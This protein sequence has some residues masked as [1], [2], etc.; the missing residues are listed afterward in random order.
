MLYAI[1]YDI[2]DDKRRGQ[3]AKLLRD[4]GERVQYSVFEA[5][6][7]ERELD[8]I[9]ERMRGIVDIKEDTVRFYA[10]CGSCAGRIEILGEGCVTQDPDII[11]V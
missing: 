11:V 10:I 3:V 8:R 9:K 7:T 6:L 1:C 5:I 4:Y 2:R